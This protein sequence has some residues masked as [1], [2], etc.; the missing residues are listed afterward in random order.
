MDAPKETGESVIP[1]LTVGSYLLKQGFSAPEIYAQDIQNGLILLEDMGDDLLARVCAQDPELE[2]LTY[3]ASVGTLV[4]LQNCKLL[5]DVPAYDTD[6]YLREAN[7]LTD[8]YLPAA[9]GEPVGAVKQAEYSD[10]IGR[11]CA[12]IAAQ[13]PCLV[14]RD[15][16]AENLL[17]LP[18]RKDARRIALLDFQDA[19]IGHPA[20]D[21]VSLLEDARR[22]TTTTLRHEMIDRYLNA[23][24]HNRTSF[25]RAYATLGAQRNLKI[26]GI[27]SRLCLRDGKCG[28]LDLIPRVWAHLQ[29]DLSHP[30][31]SDL[32]NWVINNVP[33]PIRQTL[34]QIRDRL[35]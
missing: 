34:S 2:R 32:R 20:Y 16:H 24:G 12:G 22:D 18:L 11:A 19:L 28:Y 7:L 6:V 26:I 14:L 17:W 8:W 33:P 5:P 1:F 10:L 15:Y 21:L 35:S 9:T 29:N 27:F 31:L 30:D 3:S 4:A 13:K 23:T 25:M